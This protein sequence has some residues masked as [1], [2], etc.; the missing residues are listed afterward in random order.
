MRK[1]NYKKN[2][3]NSKVP[4]EVNDM[5]EKALAASLH[6][7]G[8]ND[9]AW[10][11]KNPQLVKD[12]AS[13]PFGYP[14]GTPF[15]VS[16]GSSKFQV[17]VPGVVVLNYMTTIGT[18]NGMTSAANTAATNLYSWIRQANSGHANY[19]QPDLMVYILAM[20]SLY[21]LHAE[22]RRIYG[23]VQAYVATNRYYPRGILSALGVNVDDF[24]ANLAQFR[25]F[26]NLSA[27][28][29]A[30]YKI[31]AKFSFIT[32]HQW[33]SSSMFVDSVSSKAQT[34]LFRERLYWKFNP[35]ATTGSSL[36]VMDYKGLLE[37]GLITV[38]TLQELWKSMYGAIQGNEDIGIMSG[39]ILKAFPNDIL[40]APEIPENYTVIPEYD[41][42]VLMQIHNS[43]S[44]SIP[45][46]TKW[47]DIEITQDPTVG[48]GNLSMN[49]TFTRLSGSYTNSTAQGPYVLDFYQDA[50]SPDDV[51]EA[52]RLMSMA[53]VDTANNTVTL[54]TCGSEV[55][56][57]YTLCKLDWSGATPTFKNKDFLSALSV[58]ATTASSLDELAEITSLSQFDWAPRVW[59]NATGASQHLVYIGDIDVYTQIEQDSLDMMHRV[60]LLSE[61]EYT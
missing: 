21:T 58:T 34:Y 15:S 28:Q 16:Y 39:D 48:G 2:L 6:R 52:T 47:A 31:P 23:L 45:D 19:D 8:S 56:L 24:I 13:F 7:S 32:R 35:T 43:N 4:V 38:Y 49:A 46:D 9:P 59:V 12:S 3:R 50:P 42:R 51:M 14:T 10:Y 11:S 33:M 27:R 18:G 57:Y 54:T 55:V 36:F 17:A 44:V 53:S 1:K 25:A 5:D 22:M 26:V 20:D 61:F 40:V 41:E 37:D 29:L 30:S 60:A